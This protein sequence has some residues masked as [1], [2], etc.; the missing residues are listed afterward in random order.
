MSEYVVAPKEKIVAIADKVRENNEA[1]TIDDIA[2][3][4][5]SGGG[6]ILKFFGCENYEI[7]PFQPASHYGYVITESGVLV[8]DIKFLCLISNKYL[9]GLDLTATSKDD[10]FTILT[11]FKLNLNDFTQCTY[12]IEGQSSVFNNNNINFSNSGNYIWF[13]QINLRATGDTSYSSGQ[14]YTCLLMY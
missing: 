13:P 9:S 14:G 11:L 6:E 3:K 5:G 12:T 8:S 10:E 4:I 2:E 7:L 1:L